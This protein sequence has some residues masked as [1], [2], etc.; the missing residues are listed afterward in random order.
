MHGE[1]LKYA[2]VINFNPTVAL[3]LNWQFLDCATVPFSGRYIV[4]KLT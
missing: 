4:T 3:T 2:L 1:T